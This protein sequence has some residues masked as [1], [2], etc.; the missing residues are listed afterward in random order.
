[1]L[2]NYNS[3]TLNILKLFFVYPTTG[4]L[5]REIARKTNIG[6]PSVINHLNLLLKDKLIMKQESKPYPLFKANRE[7]ELFKSLKTFDTIFRIKESGLLKYIY[8]STLP[9]VIILFGSASKGEDIEQSDIDLYIQA[10]EK[11]L[12]LQR[13]ESILN[14]KISLFFKENFLRINKELRNNII[15]GIILKGYLKVF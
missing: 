6:E 11:R 7:N 4:F 2:K 14:R 5:I 12:D 13:Y 8:D 10:K 1:M 3:N 9:N 15:N